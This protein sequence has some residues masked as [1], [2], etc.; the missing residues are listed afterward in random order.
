M[1]EKVLTYIDPVWLG[2]II[3]NTVVIIM[4]LLGVSLGFFMLRGLLRIFLGKKLGGIA[5]VLLVIFF[6]GLVL[7]LYFSTQ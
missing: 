5:F 1:L 6:G 7:P 4:T 2:N 3:G